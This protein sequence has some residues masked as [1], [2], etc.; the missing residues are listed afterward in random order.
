MKRFVLFSGVALVVILFPRSTHAGWTRTY[1]G[2]A[3]EEGC[4]V[5]KTSDGGYIIAGRQEG[6]GGWL[7]R[8]DEEG[9]TLW[10]SYPSG[11]MGGS[12]YSV[13]QTSDGGYILAGY[14][15]ATDD[16]K[17]HLALVKISSTGEEM[18]TRLD[19]HWFP[20]DSTGGVGRSAQ[21]TAD[22]G[23]ILAG[24]RQPF[25]FGEITD[26]WL[27][28]TDSAGDL[29]WSRTYGSD[30][31]DWGACVR[32]TSDGGYII[33]GYSES[34]NSL[35]LLKTDEQGDTLWTLS[36]SQSWCAGR[37]YCVQE[38]S[39]GGYIATGCVA[40]FWDG[41]DHLYLLKIDS[42]G[43]T[44]WTRGDWQW[45]DEGSGGVGCSVQETPDGG[46]II[47]GYTSPWFDEIEDLWLIKTDSEG[48]TLW[49][50]IYGGEAEDLANC[51]DQTSD[52]GYI[53]AGATKSFSVDGY[54]LWLLKT[55]SLG[56]T[57]GV[58][59]ELVVDVGSNWYVLS[60]IGSE[61]VL[62]YS[63]FPHGF[64]AQVFDALGQKVDELHSVSPSG[65]LT[66]GEDD[67][68]YSPGVYFIRSS[69]EEPS[70]TQKVILIK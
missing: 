16:G 13:Q 69:S 20:H 44:L 55:N 56:D 21:E 22:G 35:W 52:G 27:I 70:V 36:S 39:D 10:T 61:I 7:L 62:R 37:G 19:A 59:E 4:C 18:W 50:R 68:C 31:P 25:I 53:V 48:D 11:F 8:T 51:V 17:Y 43:D 66:W 12:A 42:E 5:Q 49:T 45:F 3:D 67:G 63:D 23:Y 29:E 40:P 26:L 9:D 38:I 32:Q 1:G 24:Y 15:A 28:K 41:K 2:Q 54:D 65:T 30:G 64:H 60:P 6:E 57:L 33:S 46:Y 14:Q 47:A 58:I 34:L